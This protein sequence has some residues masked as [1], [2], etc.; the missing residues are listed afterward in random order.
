MPGTQRSLGGYHWEKDRT[1]LN[2]IDESIVTFV[3]KDREVDED[4]RRTLSRE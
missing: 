4:C 3:A 1:D 2:Q